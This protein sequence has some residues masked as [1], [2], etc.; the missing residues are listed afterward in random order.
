MNVPFDATPKR[1]ANP[2]P[3]PTS[4][5]DCRQ[6]AGELL[7]SPDLPEDKVDGVRN[8]KLAPAIDLRDDCDC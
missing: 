6:R 2:T 7:R 4:G 5:V 8:R 1:P 3:R